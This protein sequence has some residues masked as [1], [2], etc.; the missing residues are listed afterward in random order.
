M[1]RVR[2]TN[3]KTGWV[4]IYK[5]TSH[6]DPVTKKSRPIR[7]YIGY[8]DP[9]TKEFIPSSGKPGRKR[10]IVE[11]EGAQKG[12]YKEDYKRALAELDKQRA[13]NRELSRQLKVMRMQLADVR[14]AANKLV[15]TLNATIPE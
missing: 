11:E 4:S 12:S 1:S 2:Y 6:Y 14:I 5:S 15:S 7:K 10:K 13:E 3:K 9:V 8:E